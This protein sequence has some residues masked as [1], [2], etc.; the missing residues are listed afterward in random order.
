MNK[1]YLDTVLGNNSLVGITGS[2][3]VTGLSAAISMPQPKIAVVPT[4]TTEQL[5]MHA[6][7][8]LRVSIDAN[9]AYSLLQFK[10]GCQE[11]RARAEARFYSRLVYG[12]FTIDPRGRVVG[13]T[14]RPAADFQ[15]VG[16][17]DD[18]ARM[19]FLPKSEDRIHK[20]VEEIGYNVGKSEATITRALVFVGIVLLTFLVIQVFG[21]FE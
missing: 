17:L 2:S 20:L 15:T 8:R 5:A 18:N 14:W 3:G 12:Q 4:P 6:L 1:T 7:A 11:D 21:F 16:R 10:K 9:T 19:L 13:N